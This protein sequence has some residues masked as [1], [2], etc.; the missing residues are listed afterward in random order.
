[1]TFRGRPRRI[2]PG[3]S[4]LAALDDGRLPL[5]QRSVRYHRPRAPFCGVGACTQCLVRVNGVPNVRACQYPPAPGDRVT[6]ENAWPSPRYDLLGTF[7]LLF[8]HGLDTLHGFRRPRAAAPLFQRVVRRLAGY[9]AAPDPAAP[10]PP[11]AHALTSDILVIGAGAAGRAAAQRLRAGGASV[12]LID[13]LPIESPP[14]GV[15][16]LPGVTAAFLPPPG[17]DGRFTVAAARGAEGWTL[18]GGQVVLAPGA[19]DGNLLFTGNDRP[20]VITAEGAIAF[21]D[22]KGEPPFRRA[23]LVGGGAR[24]A[25]LMERFGPHIEAVVAP[26][27]IHGRIAEMA[28]ELGAELYPRTLL[29]AAHGA[30]AV[31][32]ATLRRRGGGETIRL[33]VDAVVLAHRRLPNG[34]LFFQVGARMHW[35]GGT[36]AYYPTLDDGLRTSVAGV[37]AAGEAAGFADPVGAEASGIAVAE[38]VLGRPGHL[39]DLPPRVP[40]TG[41]HEL[42]G[43]YAELLARPARGKCL[44]CPCEDVLLRELIEAHD[45][46]YRGIEV[47]KRYTSLGTGLCQGR[48][49]LPDALL[50]L[51][52]WERRPAAEVGYITQRP[53]VLPV[54][55]AALAALEESPAAEGA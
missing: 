40:E 41:P 23:L 19:Y 35:R 8:P 18:H 15:G 29:V 47:I 45:A 46:G 39:A 50:L 54:P 49:C 51:A 14:S 34:Q 30:R 6:T 36:G 1:M 28:A 16:I 55:L 17:V 48:Y 22:P 9:G 33:S 31:R 27:Q 3:R 10:R 5:L 43:Y 24:A 13:R 12:V 25:E 37:Y 7:D 20:G 52:Q 26:T 21:R 44:A 4:L 38:S 11:S 42:E 32:G 53:P 2:V